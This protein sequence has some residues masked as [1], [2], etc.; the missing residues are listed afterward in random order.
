M[1][2]LVSG[3]ICLTYDTQARITQSIFVIA[4][5]GPVNMV[6]K[7]NFWRIYTKQLHQLCH[8]LVMICES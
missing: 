2:D 3:I 7:T 8:K 5:T 1:C 6:D 4:E